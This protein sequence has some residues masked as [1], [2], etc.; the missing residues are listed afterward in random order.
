MSANNRGAYQLLLLI[1]THKLA[2]KAESIFKKSRLP[3]Q[4]RLTAEGTAPSEMIDMLG[5]G[6]VDKS[7]LVS[8]IPKGAAEDL[9]DNLKSKL[10]MHEVN[11]G[12]AFTMP[13]SGASNLIVR[14]LQ[15]SGGASLTT[16]GKDDDS[17][18]EMKNALVLA[19]INRGFSGDVMEAAKSAGATGGTVLHSRSIGNEEATAL[20]GLDA[21]AEKEL[22]MI[23]TSAKN[24]LPIMEAITQ[25]CGTHSEAK[26]LVMSLPV[27]S[28]IGV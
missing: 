16:D 8:M 11:S 1:T 10:K 4:Y 23:L 7:M 5:L 24:R 19:F 14:L 26:G 18:T 21:H 15:N 3:L 20:L 6:S 17:M 13:I 12:I 2:D 27:D 25:R 22:V 9:M 28:V